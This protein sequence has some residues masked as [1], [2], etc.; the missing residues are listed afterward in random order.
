MIL[1]TGSTPLHP[2][3]SS[4]RGLHLCT[5]IEPLYVICLPMSGLD[6]C[7]LI[8]SLHGVHDSVR[9]TDLCGLCTSSG[10]LRVLYPSSTSAPHLSALVHCT[11]FVLCT[12]FIRRGDMGRSSRSACS[13][14]NRTQHTQ[15]CGCRAEGHGVC[16]TRSRTHTVQRH[17]WY[18]AHAERRIGHS[19]HRGR[20]YVQR[21][22]WG[23]EEDRTH[24]ECRRTSVTQ[25]PWIAYGRVTREGRRRVPK[26]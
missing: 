18:A 22:R 23:T 21:S 14:R 25:H 26:A 12:R 9:G 11:R 5:Y 20:S 8:G 4:A 15:R 16:S 24:R 3:R 6:L 1:C 19:T 7:T 17:T 10:P 13:R 2:I